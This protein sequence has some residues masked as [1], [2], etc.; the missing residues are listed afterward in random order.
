MAM[1][2]AMAHFCLQ[3]HVD[4]IKSLDKVIFFS[5]S[6]LIVINLEVEQVERECVYVC[7]CERQSSL[8]P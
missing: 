1:A 2:M 3:K 8:D 4:Y 5:F 7:L 6:E